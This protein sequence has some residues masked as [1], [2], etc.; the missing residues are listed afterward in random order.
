WATIHLPKLP[1]ELLH[2]PCRGPKN[3]GVVMPDA[4]KE[5]TLNQ[6]VGAAFGAAGQ[7]CMA[8]STAVLVGEAKK[9]LPDLV[10]KA[11]KLQVNAGDQPGADVGPLIS[12]EAK[13]RVCSLIDSGVKQGAALLL[14][15]RSI[16]VKGYENGNFVGPTILA[17]VTPDMTCY[18]EEIF[19]PVLVVL[20]A[21]NLD[22]AIDIVNK[23]PYGN[24]TAIFTTNGATARKYAH[25]ADVGQIG[26]NVPI[27]VPLPMFSFTGSRASFR[28]DTNFYG[29]Q[30]ILFYTQLKTV[31]SQWKEE[32]ATLSSP[33]VVMPT[34]GR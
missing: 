20:G 2:L 8:L 23:N 24:G 5:N 11:K 6:L 28:G 16:K 1:L 15:G 12:K 7:R 4:N 34:M 25:L 18:K 9:W 32:D 19:G 30:G 33:A 10:E 31:T 3:H 27:P 17:N 22:E 26:V 29:K 14:D 21:D 13:R